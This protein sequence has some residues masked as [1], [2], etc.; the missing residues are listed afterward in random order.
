V[1]ISYA[2]Y[3]AHMA[4]ER[5]TL[6]LDSATIAAAR[7][8]AGA[9]GMSLSAWIDRAARDRAIENA[10][11]ISAAQ[12]TQLGREFRDWDSAAADRMF[13]NAA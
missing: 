3:D 6:T 9:A 5:V 11:I 7:A 13:G 4:T 12:D 2:R 10:A 1:C 8:A